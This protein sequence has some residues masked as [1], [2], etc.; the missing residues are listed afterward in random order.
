MAGFPGSALA[1]ALLWTGA[2][3]K[4]MQVTLTALLLLFWFV[5]AWTVREKV[6]FPLQTLSNLLA[7]LREGDFSIRARGGQSED[8]L[9]EL[10]IELN[11]ISESLRQ[12][13]LGALE[14]TALLRKVME[15]IEVAIFT[16]DDGNQLRFVNRAGQKLLGKPVERLIGLTATELGLG[17]CLGGGAARIIELNFGSA[18]GRWGIRRS[19]FR[20]GG[21]PH[22]L[23]VLTDLS[24][25]LREEE[26][27]AWQ[28]LVRVMGHELNNSLAPI[29]SIAGSIENLIGKNPMPP[30]WKADVTDGLK[31]I[32]SRAE[33]LARF[34]EGYRSLA[35]LPPPQKRK[36]EVR[37]MLERV[38][39]LESRLH[40][41]LVPGP[42]ALIEADLDQIEQLLI[43]LIRNAADA[44]LE[45]EQADP[46]NVGSQNRRAPAGVRLGWR[47]LP[48][49][50]EITIEDNG[51]GLANTANL[52]TPFFTTKPGGSGIG[53]TLSRQIAEAHDGSLTLQNRTDGLGCLAVLKLPLK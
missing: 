21:L 4:Q 38:A 53:L 23:L 42:D 39:Q 8:A 3:E 11:A 14:A 6:R 41:D 40:V 12:Q 26:R 47:K 10:I 52:F 30:D 7:G 15:E 22:Q 51:P 1:C 5:L 16:F 49:G 9:G 13:R 25:T 32:H 18:T 17:E 37:P 35:R 31:I 34:V 20:E 28:R 2:F 43:N 46:I 36:I 50:L 29:K 24:R 45:R 44:A 33:A 27:Q 48:E 19:S